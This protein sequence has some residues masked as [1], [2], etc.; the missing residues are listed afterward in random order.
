MDHLKPVTLDLPTLINCDSKRLSSSQRNRK[1][2]QSPERP[3][4]ASRPSHP[5][6]P[7]QVKIHSGIALCRE[8]NA[9]LSA[10]EVDVRSVKPDHRRSLI[11]ALEDIDTVLSLINGG[12]G[13]SRDAR[14]DLLAAAKEAGVRHFAPNK[15]APSNDEGVD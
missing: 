3:A 9:N 14:L 12:G 8:D 7:S 6:R 4:Q 2:W 15:L 1:K 13:F 5:E 11:S 10:K